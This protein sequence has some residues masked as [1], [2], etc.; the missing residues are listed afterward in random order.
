V[1]C[2]RYRIYAHAADHLIELGRE[3]A[4]PAEQIS[5]WA[6]PPRNF[7]PQRARAPPARFTDEGS[8]EARARH[9]PAEENLTRLSA[10]EER[11]ECGRRR[12]GK[13]H[14]TATAAH[15]IDGST[16]TAGA[17][18][19]CFFPGRAGTMSCWPEGGAQLFEAEALDR[20]QM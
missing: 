3:Q 11:Y 9:P 8:A 17:C 12:S 19:W 15:G 2:W 7:R 1:F 18:G 4:W 20:Q 6:W 13:R 16:R 5:R 10:S 14:R